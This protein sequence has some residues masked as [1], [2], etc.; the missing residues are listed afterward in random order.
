MTTKEEGRPQQRPT[1][2]VSERITTV[3]ELVVDNL[4]RLSTTLVLIYLLVGGHVR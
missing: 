1:S 2:L 3:E 4:W